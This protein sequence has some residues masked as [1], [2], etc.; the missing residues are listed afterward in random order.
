VV[1]ELVGRS[2]GR[3]NLIGEHTDHDDGFLLPLARGAS[4]E[5]VAAVVDGL[6]SRTGLVA[7]VLLTRAMSGTAPAS[8]D[9]DTGD[10]D[11]GGRP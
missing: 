9:G 11:E 3:V 1:R 6:G 10:D 7:Q 2:P 5:L 8:A 4:D